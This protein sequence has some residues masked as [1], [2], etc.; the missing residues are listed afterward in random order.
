VVA[1]NDGKVLYAGRKIAGYGNMVVIR[2]GFGFSTVYAHNSKLMVRRGQRVKCGQRIALSGATG[3][4]SGPHL[5]FELRH[6]TE[7]VDPFKVLVQ[8]GRRIAKID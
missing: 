2:H 5:H 4:A 6:G 7:A 3:K 8:P 1:A